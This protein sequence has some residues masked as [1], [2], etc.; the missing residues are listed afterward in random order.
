MKNVHMYFFHVDPNNKVQKLIK[1]PEDF[2]SPPIFCQ[3]KTNIKV[4]YL[5]LILFK[6]FA[7]YSSNVIRRL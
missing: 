7:T 5:H 2:Q 1:G 6:V 3:D 4:C